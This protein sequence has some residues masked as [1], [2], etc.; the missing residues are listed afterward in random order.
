MWIKPE[1]ILTFFLLINFS[2]NLETFFTSPEIC[3]GL[4]L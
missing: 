2:Y 3:A 1:H 4:P